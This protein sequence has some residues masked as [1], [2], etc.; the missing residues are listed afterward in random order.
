MPAQTHRCVENY[1]Q[2]AIIP[3]FCTLSPSAAFHR[4]RSTSLA[5][6]PHLLFVFS[7]FSARCLRWL[8]ERASGDP[9][10]RATDGMAPIH[11]AASSGHLDCLRY[12]VEKVGISDHMR[13]AE[14]A[15]PLHYAAGAGHLECVDWLLDQIEDKTLERDKGGGTPVHDAAEI[16][17]VRVV[18][19]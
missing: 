15:T 17:Q 1:T 2:A 3:P 6:F 7:L 19:A 8:V 11:A 12:L 18:C 4:L 14:G 10:L 16:G 5:S 13:S 9:L